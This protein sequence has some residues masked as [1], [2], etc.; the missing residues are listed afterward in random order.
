MARGFIWGWLRVAYIP[1]DINR[2]V[3]GVA[4]VGADEARAKFCADGQSAER[5]E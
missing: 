5:G 2:F 1:M 3:Q 4:K